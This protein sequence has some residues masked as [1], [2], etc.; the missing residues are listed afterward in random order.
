MSEELKPCPFC[1][2]KPEPRWDDIQLDFVHC[3]NED[4]DLYGAEIT[5]EYWNTRAATIKSDNTQALYNALAEIE[6]LKA[7]IKQLKAREA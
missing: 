2:D 1:G 3:S 5:E 4:C 7:E 6:R